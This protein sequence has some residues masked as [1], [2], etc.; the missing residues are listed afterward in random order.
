MPSRSTENTPEARLPAPDLNDAEIDLLV[1]FFQILD[2]WDREE[3][4]RDQL[5]GISHIATG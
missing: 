5:K 2:E 4:S 1:N 3:Q